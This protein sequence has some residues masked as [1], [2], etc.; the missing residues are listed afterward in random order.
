MSVYF[1]GASSFTTLTFSAAAFCLLAFAASSFAS[2]TYTNQVDTAFTVSNTDLLQTNL[3]SA[4]PSPNAGSFQAESIHGAPELTNG[5]FGAQGGSGSNGHQAAS[6]DAGQ[7]IDYVLDL[8]VATQGYSLTSI[9]TYAGWDSFRGGQSYTVA[10][11][12][13]ADPGTF[14]NIATAFDDFSSITSGLN[15]NHNTHVNIVNPTGFLASNVADIR[16]TFNGGLTFGFAGYRELDVQGVPSVPEPASCVLF[17][18]GAIGLCTV[19]RR[20]RA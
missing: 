19:A 8:S 14:I 15:G 2:V 18:L 6:G 3:S 4:N 13:V 12:T 7:S 20:R 16:F 10:Y 11:S 1:I 17:G 9:D 5:I